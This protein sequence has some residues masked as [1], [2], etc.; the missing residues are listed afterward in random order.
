MTASSFARHKVDDYATWKK[1][2]DEVAPLRKEGGVI[3]ESVHCDPGDPNTVM[4]YHQY[5]D[6]STAQ[7]FLAALNSNEE[8]QSVLKKAG[9]KPETLEVWIGEDIA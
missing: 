2:Y 1:V 7:E 3:A 6:L 8:L 9:V 4:V 5:T